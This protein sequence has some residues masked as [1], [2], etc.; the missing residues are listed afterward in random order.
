[1]N[2]HTKVVF[3]RE[4]YGSLNRYATSSH[5]DNRLRLIAAGT[6]GE[7]CNTSAHFWKDEIHIPGRGRQDHVL[8]NIPGYA[9]ISVLA[10]ALAPVEG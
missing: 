6:V 7:L 3:T 10:N 5:D 2:K 1:M 4:V 9:G 8:V